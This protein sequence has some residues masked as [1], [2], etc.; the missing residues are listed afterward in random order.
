MG[1]VGSG[2]ERLRGIDD[3]LDPRSRHNVHVTSAADLDAIGPWSHET[4]YA[5]VRRA[6]DEERVVVLDYGRRELYLAAGTDLT[7]EPPR[8]LGLAAPAA[9][10][11]ADPH[12]IDPEQLTTA[13][14]EPVVVSPEFDVLVPAFDWET[15]SEDDV[16]PPVDR[17]PSQTP[18]GSGTGTPG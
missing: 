18:A 17:Q 4:L 3:V 13:A 2:L 1:R 15:L 11:V 14:V 5:A 8:G 12:R 9:L 10:R 7:Y 16:L 6:D